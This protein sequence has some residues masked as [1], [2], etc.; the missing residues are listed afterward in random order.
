[1]T[2]FDLNPKILTHLSIISLIDFSIEV[3]ACKKNNAFQI[4]FDFG[5]WNLFSEQSPFGE[6]N[7]KIWCSK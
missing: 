6:K 1:M 5:S 7:I 2:K 4:V 3:I